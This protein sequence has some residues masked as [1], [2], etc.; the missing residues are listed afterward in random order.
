MRS[1][2]SRN[3]TTT[4]SPG[5]VPLPLPSL[6]RTSRIAS[7]AWA[8]VAT[9]MPIANWLGLSRRIRCTMRGENW[10]IASW[11]TTIVIV[12]TS[13]V[14][15]TIDVAT[16]ER[17]DEGGVGPAGE[18]LRDEPVVERVVDPERREGERDA[19]EHAEHGHEPEA[20]TDVVDQ[21]E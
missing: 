2:T 6:T 20:R 3:A 11:T 13:A 18:G 1:R 9:N 5:T 8:N 14:R 7:M 4:A 12:K 10:P 16:A 21:P 19:A 17:I 15:L